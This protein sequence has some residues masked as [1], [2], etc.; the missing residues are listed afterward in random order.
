MLVRTAEL[1]DVAR[2][3]SLEREADT[4]AHW[5]E[6]NYNAIFT[7]SSPRRVALVVECEEEA[8]A[9]QRVCGFIVAR[10]FEREW[11]IENI[12]VA[13]SARRRGFASQ[14]VNVLLQQARQQ[15]AA[16]VELEVRSTNLGAIGLYER[17]GFQKS[18]VRKSYYDNPLDDA[19]LYRLEII[20]AT[21]E[22]A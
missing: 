20:A 5:T 11:E 14:L 6:Q 15:G 2:M 10:C 12:A 22:S 16:Q 4:A 17:W 19:F 21:P 9:S 3:I 1:D 18:G 13:L 8:T 7:E